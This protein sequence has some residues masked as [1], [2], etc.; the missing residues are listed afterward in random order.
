MGRKSLAFESAI[1]SLRNRFLFPFPSLSLRALGLGD[2]G[3]LNNLLSGNGP[4]VV[5]LSSESR[6]RKHRRARLPRLR[7]QRQLLDRW[8][9]LTFTFGRHLGIRAHLR[10]GGSQRR[11]TGY[12][13][14]L[15]VQSWRRIAG[16]RHVALAVQPRHDAREAKPALQLEG[17]LARAY[18]QVGK[19]AFEHRHGLSF[20]SIVAWLNR[21]WRA[22]C[23]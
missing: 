19:R 22:R 16:A 14:E 18:H 3:R 8:V 7:H 15:K 6:D 5:A 17:A 12:R 1:R 11:F 10:P 21:E 2:R 9:A 4:R 13:V 20:A 23:A